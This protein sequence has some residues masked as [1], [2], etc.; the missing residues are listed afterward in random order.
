MAGAIAQYQKALRI[1][2]DY[3]EACYNLGNTFYQTGRTEEAIA[4]YQRALQ[5]N[6]DY[7]EVQNNLARLLATCPEASLRNGNQAVALAQRANQLTG[8][9]NPVVLE[10][11]GRCLRRG[12]ALP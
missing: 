11:L 2:P 5:I 9:E 7:V 1:N 8:D 4:Y 10:H 3:A 12:R 6:P